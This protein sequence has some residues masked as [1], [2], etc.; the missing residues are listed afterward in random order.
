MAISP[1][2]TIPSAILNISLFGSA[3]RNDDDEA[4][5]LDV[6]VIVANGTG[7]TAPDAVFELVHQRFGKVPSLS[8][9][10]LRKIKALFASGDL[11]SWHLHLEAK[12][13]A[14]NCMSDLVGTPCDYRTALSDINDLRIIAGRVE[15]TIEACR[16]NAVFEMGI[17]YVCARNIAMAASSRLTSRPSFGR[18]SPFDLPLKFP[19][20]RETY[21]IMLQ[22]RMA[23]QRGTAPPLVSAN[24][25]LEVQRRL[26]IWSEVVACEVERIEALDE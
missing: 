17:L 2:T 19:V 25:V 1:M 14:G 7:E 10:G 22:C 15:Q 23:S 9:Y 26:L 5:D 13:L 18:Y 24:Q 12:T 21:Q 6:L 20:D 11:F 16:V 4:S 8:W 3:A